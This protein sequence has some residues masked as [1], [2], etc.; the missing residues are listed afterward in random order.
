VLDREQRIGLE[1]GRLT[2]Q[3]EAKKK[4]AGER[5]ASLSGRTLG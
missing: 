1:V 2:E 3:E 5:I 4:K